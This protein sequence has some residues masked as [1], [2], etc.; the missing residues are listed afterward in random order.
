MGKIQRIK[1]AFESRLIAVLGYL[2]KKVRQKN[3]L[4]VLARQYGES[5]SLEAFEQLL[6]MLERL[7]SDQ[8][9]VLLIPDD[10]HKALSFI[11]RHIGNPELI[12]LSGCDASQKSNI[13]LLK[14]DFL[15]QAH[16]FLTSHDDILFKHFENSVWLILSNGVIAGGKQYTMA[17]FETSCSD[18][19]KTSVQGFGDT[20]FSVRPGTN[21]YQIVNEVASSY[22]PDIQAWLTKLDEIRQLKII[23]LG[24]H[25]GSFSIQVNALL[26][27]QCDIHIY[28][29]EPSNFEQIKINIAQN[30]AGNITP[31][32]LAVSSV[33]G[34]NTLYF[35]P[36]H[37]GAHQLGSSLSYE[38]KTIPV[39]VV[40]LE[41]VFSKW[42]SMPIDIFKIDVE[43]SEY[44]ALFPVPELAARCRL[45]VGE[46]QRN[47]EHVPQDM[48]DFLQGL[49]F[50]VRY[51][52]DT[53]N[54]LTFSAVNERMCR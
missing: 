30:Q 52:G 14:K 7:P 36:E 50:S 27:R 49:G 1:S 31:F 6:L 33:A 35:N 2:G 43:G 28:E 24:G 11:K 17:E 37:S 9:A 3:L 54:C 25:I 48:L 39:E 5:A 4:D 15:F 8:K 42:D 20:V 29:P 46:A 22:L 16:R 26:S 21:D 44:N 12:C 41:A 34:Q 53:Q 51:T 10:M 47:K 40:T 38:T 18:S 32:N 23:D 13:F 19:L 45:I